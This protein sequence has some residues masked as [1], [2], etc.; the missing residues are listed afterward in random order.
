MV[1]ATALAMALFLCW[2]GLTR[3]D[4]GRG[5]EERN[6]L[7]LVAFDRRGPGPAGGVIS[8]ETDDDRG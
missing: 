2:N 3:Y 6:M 4:S 7:H 1:T 8:G 5:K